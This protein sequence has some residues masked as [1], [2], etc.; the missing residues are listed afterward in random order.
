MFRER[1]L[2]YTRSEINKEDIEIFSTHT[3]DKI[4]VSFADGLT[5]VVFDINSVFP[6]NIHKTAIKI[7]TEEFLEQLKIASI[8]IPSK[9]PNE[10]GPVLLENSCF[11]Y[12]MLDSA[13]DLYKIGIS[14]SA[15]YREKTLQGEKPSIL[16]IC[17]KEYPNRIIAAAI[18]KALH[19]AFDKKRVSGEWFNLS[20]EEVTMIIKTLT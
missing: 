14:K 2:I 9:T 1:L 18:E 10:I 17:C 13:N 11:V 4:K 8:S 15:E 7:H 6:H 16:L 20:A 19:K 3:V 5:P 12:L